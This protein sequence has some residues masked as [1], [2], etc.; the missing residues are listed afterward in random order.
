MLNKNFELSNQNK[1]Y[2]VTQK[3]GQ[4]PMV[5]DQISSKMAGKNFSF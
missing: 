1:I 5:S 4:R 2:K 3:S